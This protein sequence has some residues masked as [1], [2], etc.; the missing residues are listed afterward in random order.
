MDSSIQLPA[1]PR[2]DRDAVRRD[3]S[4]RAWLDGTPQLRGIEAYIGDGNAEGFSGEKTIEALWS[5]Y[6]IHGY[7]RL[8]YALTRHL[9]PETCVEIGILQGYSLFA[10]AAALRDNG[11]GRVHGFDLFEDYPYHH[12]AQSFVSK[13][14]DAWKFSEWACMIRAD[15]HDVDARFDAVDCLHVDISN[16]GDVY[17]RMFERWADKVRM[18]MVFEGGSAERD[19]VDWMIRYRKPPIVSALDEIR[20][21]YRDWTISVLEP[22]PSLTVAARRM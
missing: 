14:L 17:R 22:F 11:R 2:L 15:A 16:D 20:A 12:E 3:P 13:R 1:V 8:F 4:F 9:R 5:S 6:R 7:G 19:R 10:V 21:K 18:M